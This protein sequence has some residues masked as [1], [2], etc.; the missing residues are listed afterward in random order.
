M[1][2]GEGGRR[3]EDEEELLRRTLTFLERDEVETE[4]RGKRSRRRREGE[5]ARGVLPEAQHASVRGR[6]QEEVRSG[7]RS[8]GRQP[9]R[10]KTDGDKG[11][12]EHV[13]GRGGGGGGGESKGASMGGGGLLFDGVPLPLETCAFKEEE[14]SKKAEGPE[15]MPP[16]FR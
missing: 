9:Q 16:W 2:R 1:A 12:S 13:Q 10:P 7:G 5:A 3:E 6:R 11:E 14:E 4:E 8:G 15:D